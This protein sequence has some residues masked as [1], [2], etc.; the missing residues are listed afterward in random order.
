MWLPAADHDSADQSV[1]EIVKCF[2]AQAMPFFDGAQTTGG[3]LNT[4]ENEK[5]GSMHHL[6][7]ERACAYA[8]HGLV[9]SARDATKRAIDLDRKDGR[10]WCTK[11]IALSEELLAAVENG[12]SEVLLTRWTDHSIDKLRLEKFLKKYYP[13]M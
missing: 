1:L 9:G 5:W 10:P 2:K 6:F 13:K 8:H 12:G 3:Y 11:G 7:F 4:L